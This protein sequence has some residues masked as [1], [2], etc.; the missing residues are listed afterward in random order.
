MRKLPFSFEEFKEIY[1]KVPRLCVE[2][3]IRTEKG[4][5]LTLR[6]KNGYEGQWHMPG[7]TVYYREGVEAAVKRIASEE[8]G[9]EVAVGKFLGYL[10][11]PSEEKERGFGYTVSL[12]FECSPKGTH[13]E[14]DDQAE[15]ADFF[16]TPPDNTIAEQK[17]FLK[18]GI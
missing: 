1:S 17:E 9:M 16:I 14:L 18:N 11:Y 6:Q 8:V 2:L 15:K 12:V 5:L 7:G 13:L 10:E 3:V 4:V